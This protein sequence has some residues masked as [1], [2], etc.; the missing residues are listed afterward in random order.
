MKKLIF[1]TLLFPLLAA[2]HGPNDAAHQQYCVGDFKLESGDAIKDF[3]ISYV[4]HGTLNANKSN[5]VLMVTALLVR[6]K[7]GTPILFSQERAGRFGR[8]FTI[9]KFRTMTDNRDSGGVLLPDE[10]R[11]TSFGRILRVSSLDEL[12]TLVAINLLVTAV[13]YL[14]FPYIWRS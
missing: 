7:L 6:W 14:L 1:S 9:Y 3:C 10:I 8:P 12:L 5:A 13:S 2:A 11:L 4:T